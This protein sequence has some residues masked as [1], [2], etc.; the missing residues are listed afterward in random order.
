VLTNART[1]LR[2]LLFL[3][4]WAG[5]GLAFAADP[6]PYTVKFE[7]TRNKALDTAIKSS[8]QL[9]SLR[10][11]APAGPLALM[12]RAKS[13]VS[14]MQTACD[15]FGFYGREVRVTI[16]GLSLDDP[17]L[18]TRLESS[19]KSPAVVVEIHIETGPLF[20]LRK[21]TLEGDVSERARGAF[22][23]NPGA[24]AA[25]T[26][27]LAA[28]TRLQAAL[29]EE[30]NAYAMVEE[31][32]AHE[33]AHE[34]L[35]DV[36]YKANPG[37]VYQLGPI[38]F[39]GLKRM[40]EAFVRRL[41]T[42]HPGDLY[43]ASRIEHAR[44]DLLSLGVF[45][46]VTVTLPKQEEVTNGVLP[47]TFQVTERKRHVIS[48]QGAYSTDL[49]V[50]TGVTWTD[51]NTFGNAENLAITSSLINAGG[52]ATSGV[53]Y[54]VGA[55]LTQPDF[56]RPDQSLQYSVGV[57][58]Q[59]LEAYDQKSATAGVAINRTLGPR[60]KASVGLTVEQEE[61]QQEKV[62]NHYTLLSVP[63]TLKF[64][65]T[66]LSNPLTDPTHGF[67]GSVSVTPTESLTKSYQNIVVVPGATPGS[68]EVTTQTEPGNATFAI[69]QGS[70]SAYL[71]LNRFGWTD[72]GKS[73]IAARLLAARMYGASQFEIPPDQRFYGGGSATVRGYAYQSIGPA[74]PD[75]IPEGGVQLFA[76][77][78]ELR[79]HFTENIACALFVD[80]GTVSGSN[81]VFEGRYKTGSD[82]NGTGVGTGLRYYTPI[83]PVRVDVAF[84]LK[85][86]DTSGSFQVYVGLGQAF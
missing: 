34:P 1:T 58:K 36:I 59:H 56:L 57:L 75:H 51:R 32:M 35:V 42:I 60:W 69:L 54:Q 6:Q 44:T 49:G 11:K 62:N 64:D 68:S 63:I 61:I 40:H 53:G 76:A 84:P 43:V 80:T 83:G 45:S 8:S 86:T 78:I 3:A 31:P 73:V 33:D 7:S 66:G 15:S 67:R 5:A 17:A 48:L 37:P 12:G 28:G 2:V 26:D 25:A 70:V 47:I 38:Q 22:A 50:S 24:S 4:A 81:N 72:P 71:D 20:H 19:P 16:A 74:F 65:N 79:Q 23:L 9:E 18:L 10:A 30:G 46:G 14:R 77:G 29:Q 39:K 13:D 85:R 55:T 21:V 27:V 82:E 41:L 52:N